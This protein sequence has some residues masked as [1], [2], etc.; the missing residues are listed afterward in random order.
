[1]LAGWQDKAGIVTP[2]GKEAAANAAQGEGV[3]AV[4]A[5]A[6]KI[7]RRRR[8]EATPASGVAPP[9]PK[10]ARGVGARM[11]VVAAAV[12][13]VGNDETGDGAGGE[14]GGAAAG[15]GGGEFSAGDGLADGGLG[16]G[17]LASGLADGKLGGERVL[18][19]SGFSGGNLEG[20]ADAFAAN[21]Y[22]AARAAKIAV[23]FSKL[24]KL[25][26]AQGAP[27]G[28]EAGWKL[29]DA[30]SSGV[31]VS[32]AARHSGEVVKPTGAISAFHPRSG[33]G[34]V[35]APQSGRLPSHRFPGNPSCRGAG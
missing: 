4:V 2:A 30:F 14:G 19:S 11:A 18:G 8:A 13:N 33:S 22:E 10:K 20:V 25:G 6:S 9:P 28:C 17:G 3:P 35:A 16:G 31:P 1:M 34:H 24:Q 12:A 5:T 21:A 29:Q 27:A 26:L 7:N 23:N 15:L 32:A